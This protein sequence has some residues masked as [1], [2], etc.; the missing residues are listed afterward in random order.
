MET[1]IGTI[2]D[3]I[4]TFFGILVIIL[5]IRIAVNIIVFILL[6]TIPILGMIISNYNHFAY[7]IEMPP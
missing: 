7:L 1:I 3:F 5:N 2:L 4:K 6:L